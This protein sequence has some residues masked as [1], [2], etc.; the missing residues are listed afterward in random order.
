MNFISDNNQTLW[1]TVSKIITEEAEEVAQW[2]S[3]LTTLL[4]DLSL[5]P[6]I[7]SLLLK[8]AYNST[9]RALIL[10]GLCGYPPTHTHE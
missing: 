4:E 8:T 6:S 10:S 9:P 1:I 5:F 2:L 7:H 3:L